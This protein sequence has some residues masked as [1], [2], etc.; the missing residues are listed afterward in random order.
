MRNIPGYGTVSNDKLLEYLVNERKRDINE[1]D[2][3][4]RLSGYQS[5]F[6]RKTRTV[7][8]NDVVGNHEFALFGT[9]SGSDV[10]LTLDNNP[11][12]GQTHVIKADSGNANNIIIDGDD[13]DID[14]VGT[15]TLAADAGVIIIYFGNEGEW[16]V[17]ADV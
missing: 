12:D 4:K 17:V 3:I 9:T 7:T 1:I 15:K 11:D 16:S 13:N 5:G 2:E 8:A 6:A 14:G 10:T